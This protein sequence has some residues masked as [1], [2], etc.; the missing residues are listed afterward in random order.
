LDGYQIRDGYTVDATPFTNMVIKVFANLEMLYFATDI[1]RG[2]FYGCLFIAID[3][4]NGSVVWRKE[5]PFLNPPS[6]IAYSYKTN[7][8]ILYG[9]RCETCTPTPVLLASIS[10]TDGSLLWSKQISQIYESADSTLIVGEDNGDIY[11][12]SG[13]GQVDKFDSAGTFVWEVPGLLPTVNFALSPNES[14]LVINNQS[15]FIAVDAKSGRQIWTFPKPGCDYSGVFPSFDATGNIY[16][17]CSNYA[18][19]VDK[20]G[21]QRWKSNQ[22]GAQGTF[23]FEVMVQDSPQQFVYFVPSIGTPGDNPPKQIS[24][25]AIELASGNVNAT[26]KNI[27]LGDVTTS[28][29]DQ[30]LAAIAGGNNGII[31]FVE[32]NSRGYSIHGMPQVGG[33]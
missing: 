18:L 31:Y 12:S 28:L 5:F 21:K 10:I 3:A 32:A 26:P 6:N 25:Y 30:S 22:V 24:I 13:I 33:W 7:A 8:L 27:I 17:S 23:A 19:S 1:N 29:L 16:I 14:F 15:D 20:Y 9:G 11:L 4:N 2:L